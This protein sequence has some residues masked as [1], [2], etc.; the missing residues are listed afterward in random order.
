M[1][2][3][4]I[5]A[6]RE[7]CDSSRRPTERPEHYFNPRTPRGVRR[8]AGKPG[9]LLRRISI[10]APREGCDVRAKYICRRVHNF[11]PR[12]P[13]GVRRGT[14]GKPSAHL[15]F[16][17]RTPRGVRPAGLGYDILPDLF[18]STHPARGATSAV[19]DR[20]EVSSRFQSTPPARGATAALNMIYS[21]YVIS[22]H[23]PREGCDGLRQM[24]KLRPNNFNPRTPRGVRPWS[25]LHT[26]Q[27]GV[28][29]IHAPREGCDLSTTTAWTRWR[30]E[31]QSTHPA[32]G[33]TA[34]DPP[35]VP[36]WKIS[37]HAPREGCDR[38]S[39]SARVPW[40]LI[41]IHAPREGCDLW[42]VSTSSPVK[43]QSTHPA[44][45]ATRPIVRILRREYISIHAPREGCD[46][47]DGELRM[48]RIYFNPRTPRGVRQQTLPKSREFA[49][50]NSLICTRGRR[51]SIQKQTR[52]C[53]IKLSFMLFGCEPAGEGV[54]SWTSHATKSKVRLEGR[55]AYS[56]SVR[57]SAHSDFP[58]NKSGDCPVRGP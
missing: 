9:D 34:S 56:Q 57:S 6:P 8:D 50:L 3:I 40:R 39:T 33:A 35:P 1:L 30:T 25:T 54:S 45:G 7:G 2:S 31:F 49:W 24:P 51:L 43:F 21:D 53:S 36:D 37:I 22:I 5:H 11:N 23:A 14:T 10:H 41:S 4:S 32:R 12:T 28:I 58:R 15:D 13:R 26:S 38:T 16:N 29:S 55:S 27:S 44:R 17:P 18:Q 46:M 42:P 48:Q 52:L 47:E 19:A 20:S